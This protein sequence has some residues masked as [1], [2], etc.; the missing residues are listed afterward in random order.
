MSRNGFFSGKRGKTGRGRDGTAGTMGGT[1]P[2]VHGSRSRP[3]NATCVSRHMGK[4]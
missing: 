3:G 2:G 1:L 4:S